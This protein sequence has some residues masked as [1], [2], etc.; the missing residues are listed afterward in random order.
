MVNRGTLPPF[1]VVLKGVEDAVRDGLARAMD[2]LAALA[3]TTDEASNVE[4]VLAEALNNVVEHALA[5]SRGQ[6]QIEI[7]LRHDAAGLHITIVDFG[8]PMP[9]GKAPR[10]RAPN[11]E[12]DL[13]D[14][15]EGGFGWFMIQTL[16]ESVGYARTEN[17]NHLTLTLAVGR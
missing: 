2:G 5:G 17:A 15:P 8:Q 16:A 12:V 9:A 4:L 7:R 6:T 1:T 13:G 10:G 3:L 14:M 11:V